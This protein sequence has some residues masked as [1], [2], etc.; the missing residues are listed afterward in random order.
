MF[1]LGLLRLVLVVSLQTLDEVGKLTLTLHSFTSPPRI[2]LSRR[3]FRRLIVF[4]IPDILVEEY[5]P[6]SGRF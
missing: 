1:E 3:G 2:S 6:L 4:Q 5:S